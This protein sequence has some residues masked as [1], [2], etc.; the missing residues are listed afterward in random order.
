MT[1]TLFDYFR[2][3]AGHRVRIAL[4][5]KGIDVTR[6]PVNL[7]AGEQKSA[8]HH[9]RNP[10]NFV[11]ALDIGNAILTQSPAIL[12]WLDETFPDPPLL[13]KDALGRAK[14]RA[15]AAAVCCDIH[16]LGNLRVLMSLRN[17]YQ[18]DDAGV[19][20]WAKRWIEPGFAAI[21]AM[22]GERPV[23]GDWCWG[24]APGLADCCVVPQIFAATSRYGVAMAAYPRLARLEAAAAEHPA[25]LA[26]H[27]RAQTDAV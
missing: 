11:P 22:L 3:G 17:D 2:S 24:E 7:P 10:Q 9:A 16:P 5:L 8:A 15:I 1:L 4:A 19:A 27:P 25:F 23:D 20:A 26:A 13:P 14:V 21:E 18:L 12:E 6:I